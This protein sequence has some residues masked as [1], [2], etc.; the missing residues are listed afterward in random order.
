M[1]TV[2]SIS[3]LGSLKS[4]YTSVPLVEHDYEVII[5]TPQ[6]LGTE[7]DGETTA[8]LRVGGLVH[9]AKTARTQVA[10]DLVISEFGSNHE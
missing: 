10:G 2:V 4:N 1:M 5:T 9:V 8:Q 6:G 3:V 7:L